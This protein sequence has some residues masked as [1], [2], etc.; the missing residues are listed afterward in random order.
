VSE[1]RDLVIIVPTRNRPDNA[2]ELVEAFRQTRSNWSHAIFAVDS[3]DPE[4]PRYQSVLARRPAVSLAV[5][6]APS[7]MVLALNTV[8]VQVATSED[9]PFAIAFMGDD[10]RPRTP[11]WDQRYLT[12]LRKMGTG[13]VYGNDLLQGRN[14]PT[15][16]AMTSDIVTALGYMA[17]PTLRH[18]YV[19]NFWRSL[20]REVGRLVYLEDVIVEHVHPGAKKDDGTAKAEWDAGYE[21]VN[22]PEMWDADKKASRR[23][24][25]GPFHADAA[26]V[27]DLIAQQAQHR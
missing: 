25:A 4:L 12:I 15:Q 18:L 26:K 19:D 27:R 11:D 14:L 1:H 24:M 21:R 23:Y 5:V 10:H 17:P 16:V 22:D 13:L 3:D 20:G 9:P 8:A 2:V 6:E 7:T